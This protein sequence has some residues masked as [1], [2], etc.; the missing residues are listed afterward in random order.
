MIKRLILILLTIL[1]ITAL[2]ASCRNDNAAD[3]DSGGGKNENETDT[4]EAEAAVDTLEAR[5][6]V[7]DNVPDLDFG[8]AEFRI[9]VQ[10]FDRETMI[11]EEETGDTIS[12]AVYARNN[13]I[14]DRFNVKISVYDDTYDKINAY[15]EQ[16]I[17]ANEN[18]FELFCGQAVATS[19]LVI[20]NYMMPWQEVK[21]VDFSR[22]WWSQSTVDDLTVKDKTFVAIGDLALTAMSKTYCMYFDKV[23]AADYDLPD[24]YS[25][26]DE[27]KWTL[28]TMT[29]LTKDIYTDING[30]GAKDTED[31]FGFAT[32][33]N[34][35]LVAYLWAF[36][37][38]VMH[39]NA[40]G[41]PELA[42]KT[43][44]INSI[45][46]KLYELLFNT[47]GAY[48]DYKYVGRH[49]YSAELGIDFF[50]AGK[51]LFA[52]STIGASISELRDFE[53]DYGI[54]PYPKFDEN[55]ER[56]LTMS[57]G[58]HSVMAVAATAQNTDMIGAVTEALCAESWKTVH[59]AYYDVALKVKEAR[60][61]QSIAML[62]MIVAGR[63]Y[64]FGYIYDNW[65]G[66]SFCLE[67]IFVQGSSNFESY[68]EANEARVRTHYE[69][70]LA[71]FE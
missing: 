52:N 47:Q 37:N 24:I 54:I 25:I 1:C 8:G 45:C 70:V 49:G 61:E 60:D 20:K 42:I 36:D 13:A 2:L 18:A 27:G 33:P 43:E 3:I 58:S 6:S 12:D 29:N 67:Q 4:L 53:N 21:Y 7:S 22:E 34:S 32:D 30:D 9:V 11:A 17:L 63:I 26:V 65:Q 55:Q 51:A 16:A 46:E 69:N 35:N 64:D 23:K 44:K 10:T 38:P 68:Y 40:D 57:D 62:D 28:E 14:E 48:S 66:M 39:K 71:C 56:Y 59:P 50:K 41:I 31:Y 15:A 5:K 19:S